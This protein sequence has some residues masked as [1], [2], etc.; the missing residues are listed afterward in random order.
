[1]FELS[2]CLC[3]QDIEVRSAVF[4]FKTTFVTPAQDFRI[5]LHITFTDWVKALYIVFDCA[6]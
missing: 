2:V 6:Q 4:Q 1:M 3:V 5:S